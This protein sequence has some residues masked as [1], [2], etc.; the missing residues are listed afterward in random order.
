MI[1][2]L[3]EKSDLRSLVA[4]WKN[5][6]SD[7]RAALRQNDP[8][9]VQRAAANG[10]DDAKLANFE[11]LLDDA[12][13]GFQETPDGVFIPSNDNL[14]VVQT[15]L[16]MAYSAADMVEKPT[17]QG[18]AATMPV[19]TDQK[20]KLEAKPQQNQKLAGGIFDD[21]NPLYITK[22]IAAVA[23]RLVH[24]L[25]PFSTSP[26]KFTLASRARLVIVGDWGT[27]I[28]RADK[29]AGLMAQA[30][31]ETPDRERHA[32][33]LGDIYFCGWPDE[34]QCR[35]L[36]HWP[37]KKGEPIFSWC[38]NGNHDMYSGGWGYFDTVLKDPRFEKQGCRS[39]FLLEN[40]VWQIFGL[41]SAYEE[42]TFHE[43]MKWADGERSR[44]P[45]KKRI[46][47]SHH[48]PL[49]DYED[50]VAT[51]PKMAKLLNEAQ[52]LLRDG[53]ASAWIWGHEH[54]GVVYQPRELEFADGSKVTL[55]FGSCLGHGGV[56]T[57]PTVAKPGVRFACEGK[58]QA[59]IFNETFGLFGFGILDLDGDKA[60]FTHV[61]E[62]GVRT[63]F[64]DIIP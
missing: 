49:S 12:I 42:W 57:H 14:S 54:R 53:R 47:M 26:Q 19:V 27:G 50:D 32:I 40:D 13:A 3:L 48:Q 15:I 45:G 6:I 64:N 55:P 22:G 21:P 35:F 39:H 23:W 62:D 46:L 28:P 30:L 7:A 37:V 33:H 52:P 20:L 44:E 51:R 18:L 63:T 10:W 41:D 1:A 11:R 4:A 56:P 2:D 17:G 61:D 60:T 34:S 59:G 16:E 31:A 58:I 36:D 9:A 8:E 43:Q 5:M 24:G 38:L 29:I 25:H